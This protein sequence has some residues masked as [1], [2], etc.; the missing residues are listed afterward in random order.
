M[1]KIKSIMQMRRDLAGY[2]ESFMDYLNHPDNHPGET[3]FSDEEVM[4][5]HK[6]IFQP[7]RWYHTDPFQKVGSK[8][9]D[10]FQSCMLMLIMLGALYIIAKIN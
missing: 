2:D 7:R 1:N 9:L 5:L 3:C 10:I 4:R 8:A 6:K